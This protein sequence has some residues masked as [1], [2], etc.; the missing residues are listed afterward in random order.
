MSEIIDL[1]VI[2]TLNLDPDRVLEK[3]IGNLDTCIIIGYDKNGDEYFSSSISDGGDVIWLL[4][5]TKKKL[6]EADYD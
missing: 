1:P 6:L 4:E 2:T 5:R 3:A